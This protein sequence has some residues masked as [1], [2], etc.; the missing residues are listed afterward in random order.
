MLREL[1]EQLAPQRIANPTTE[2]GT[3]E[4][5]RAAADRSYELLVALVRDVRWISVA[6]DGEGSQVVDAG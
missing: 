2:P 1:V 6:S 4:N 3:H 5:K